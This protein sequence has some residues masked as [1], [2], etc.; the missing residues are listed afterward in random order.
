MRHFALLCL[1]IYLLGCTATHLDPAAPGVTDS[2]GAFS[3][4]SSSSGSG[5][6]GSGSAPSSTLNVIAPS[7]LSASSPVHYVATA[8]T[9]CSGGVASMGIY[10]SPGQR[11]YVTSGASLDTNLAL[12]PGSY[13]T[14]VQ[15]W[16]QCGGS[17]QASVPLIVSAP[18]SQTFPDIE[19]MS[20]WYTYPD[21]GNPI[22]SS[23][24]SITASPSLD[25]SSG[26]FH[27]GP[28]GEFNN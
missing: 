9:T 8:S 15:S 21:Q 20:G 1:C 17:A 5:S 13:N 2:P 11:A 24:P 4:G 28:T 7:V 18:G 22:C 12:N 27:L 25:G 16:D 10:A 3:P 14:T 26:K 6:S 23:K 19:Q